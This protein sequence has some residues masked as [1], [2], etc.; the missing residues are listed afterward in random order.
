MILGEGKMDFERLILP[1]YDKN[2]DFGNVKNKLDDD[3]NSLFYFLQENYNV[4]TLSVETNYRGVYDAA[5]KRIEYV[6]F[7]K[8]E[9]M[10][11]FS[12]VVT[13][14]TEESQ[15]KEL[16]KIISQFDYLFQIHDSIYDLF[17][18]KKVMAENYI[19]LKSDI[20]ILV[21]EL[22][23]ETLS[24]FGDIRKS[25]FD[26]ESVD[27]KEASSEVQ[28]HLDE[29]NRELLALLADPLRRDAG[30]LTNFV[31]YSQRLKDKLMNFHKA[32]KS[33]VAVRPITAGL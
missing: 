31:T 5:E 17:N 21:R 2:E 24:L 19:E 11:Y 16:I 25:L 12:K 20:L 7:V 10:S 28:K 3:I 29:A 15:S 6:E 1:V 27:I 14:I 8:K 26:I 9:Y 33:S 32:K 30:S 18:T 23:S 13:T 4:V 22:S